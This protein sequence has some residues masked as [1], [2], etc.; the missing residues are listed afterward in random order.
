[1]WLVMKNHSLLTDFTAL[2]QQRTEKRSIF[3]KKA[4]YQ[5]AVH[6]SVIKV[7]L[8]HSASSVA[9][10]PAKLKR[11]LT[12]THGRMVNKIADYFKRLLEFENKQGKAFVSKVTVSEKAQDAS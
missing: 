8:Y 5:W 9:M 1:M 7:I 12:K 11:H 6:A 3:T 10:V 2:V 4:T